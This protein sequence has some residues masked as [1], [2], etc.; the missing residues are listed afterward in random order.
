M[1][2]I[3]EIK[4]CTKAKCDSPALGGEGK[5]DQHFLC[6]K[7]HMRL[8]CSSGRVLHKPE[9]S[10]MS[11]PLTVIFALVA[12]IQERQIV[13][14][15]LFWV[16]ATGART[17]CLFFAIPGNARIK[18][19]S[20]LLQS[21][22]HISGRL[23]HIAQIGFERFPAVWIFFLCHLIGNGWN[24]NHI[25][26]IFPIYRRG[27][28]VLGGQ[29]YGIENPQDLV[30]IASCRHWIAHHQLNVFIG[31]DDKHG[32]HC[33][34]CCGIAIRHGDIFIGWEH[35]V[36]KRDLQ[37]RVRDHRKVDGR[38]LG[39]FDVFGPTIMVFNRINA[40]SNDFAIALFKFGFELGDA[41]PILSC[42]RACN[43]WDGKTGCPSRCLANHES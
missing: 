7:F 27:H 23:L 8:Q 17:T 19:Y 5:E 42:R 10:K 43:L 1:V 15:S 22:I 37:I 34:I 26:T 6:N 35:V 21:S 3:H 24:N 33:C 30:E 41:S 18:K 36:Q 29:L 39:L 38:A 13:W 28:L 16:L 20:A 14:L 4:F 40:E 25:L 32:A 31:S 11:F 2:Q 12:K 9:E